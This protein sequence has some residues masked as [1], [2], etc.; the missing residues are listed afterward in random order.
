MIV[1]ILWERAF[2]LYRPVLLLF[3][4]F[5]LLVFS[6]PF[7]LALAIYCFN[8]VVLLVS[9]CCLCLAQGLCGILQL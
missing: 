1:G 9:C 4:A 2:V 3:W 6:F 8:L 7:V 5:H